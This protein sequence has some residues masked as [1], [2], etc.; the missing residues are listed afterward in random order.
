MI[1]R[2]SIRQCEKERKIVNKIEK[3]QKGACKNG[4]EQKRT[5]KSKYQCRIIESMIIHERIKQ[6]VEE[7]K[8]V[9]NMKAY[10][11]VK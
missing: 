9:I 8:I 4:K 3:L 5:E 11:N 1:L 10:E 2:K 7:H 6:C